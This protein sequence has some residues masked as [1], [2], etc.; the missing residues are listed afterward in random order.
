[1]IARRGAKT[2]TTYSEGIV[3][4]LVKDVLTAVAVY[5]TAKMGFDNFWTILKMTV[6]ELLITCQI[7]LLS[8]SGQSN[9]DDDM[10]QTLINGS[11]LGY[12]VPL[13]PKPCVVLTVKYIGLMSLLTN[14]LRL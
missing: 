13:T 8:S 12:L 7:A 4:E 1:V 10:R 3:P 2:T 6:S 5:P 11:I 14:P 9:S